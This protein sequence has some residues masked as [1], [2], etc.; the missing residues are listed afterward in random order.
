MPLELSEQGPLQKAF[1]RDPA[2]L[3][4]LGDRQ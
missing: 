3:G 2:R 1:Q 4:L